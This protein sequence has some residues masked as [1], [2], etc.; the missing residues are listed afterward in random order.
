MKE[1]QLL[2]P[3]GR[4]IGR[5]D[6]EDNHLAQSGMGLHVQS[7]EPIGKPS[8]VFAAYPVTTTPKLAMGLR[9]YQAGRNSAFVARYSPGITPTS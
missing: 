6:I 7:E 9:L 4:I 2:V 1:A 3:M 8:Q 5:V